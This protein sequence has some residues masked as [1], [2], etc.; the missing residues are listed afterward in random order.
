MSVDYHRH[1]Q[2]TI[3][4][5]NGTEAQNGLSWGVLSSLASGLTN[6]PANWLNEFKDNRDNITQDFASI[7]K[8]LNSTAGNY[9]KLSGGTMSGGLYLNQDPTIDKQAA[10]K[11]YVDDAVQNKGSG[12]VKGVMVNVTTKNPDANGIVDIGNVLTSDA[13]YVKKSGDTM[14]GNLTLFKD[15]EQNMDAATKQ[16]VDSQI[17]SSGGGTITGIE[18]NGV[19]K[20][21]SGVVDLGDVVTNIQVDGVNQTLENGNVNITFST[22]NFEFESRVPEGIETQD[23]AAIRYNN[24]DNIIKI[25]KTIEFNPAKFHNV[26]FDPGDST[27]I[28]FTNKSLYEGQPF[29]KLPSYTIKGYQYS[30]WYW[31]PSGDSDVQISES[32]EFNSDYDVILYPIP[33]SMVPDPETDDDEDEE[34][35]PDQPQPDVND[36]YLN[37]PFTITGK[38]AGSVIIT[39]PWHKGVDSPFKY[40]KDN[41][42]TWIDYTY[43]TGWNTTTGW[44]TTTAPKVAASVIAFNS[45]ETIQFKAKEKVTTLTEQNYNSDCGTSQTCH[46]SITLKGNAEVS[47]NIQYLL[48]PTGKET[49]VPE[50]CFNGLFRNSTKLISAENLRLPG[51]VLGKECYSAMFFGCTN[52]KTPPKEIKATIMGTSACEK[53]FY[54]CIKLDEAPE[55]LTTTLSADCYNQM[56]YKCESLT[57]SPTFS[58]KTFGNNSC[59]EMFYSCTSLENTPTFEDVSGVSPY[60]CRSMFR[61]CSSLTEAHVPPAYSLSNYCFD[62]M[63]RDCISLAEIVLD[64]KT[65]STYCYKS[66]FSGCTGLTKATLGVVTPN[67]LVG[68]SM[69]SGCT[70]CT[71]IYL[72]NLTKQDFD[73]LITERE[74]LSSIG[75]PTNGTITIHYKQ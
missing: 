65:M 33:A 7:L 72:S 31:T 68:N 6:L 42:N 60:C 54:N 56:F 22:P 37:Q 20:G 41:G 14:L 13:N 25:P 18:M 75:R 9:L 48:D 10:T 70:N 4:S 17:G 23:I 53:M 11:K 16:Y 27:S 24:T 66:M 26:F 28:E 30:S 32:S 44:E 57:D 35:P 49:T 1:C 43:N 47:G 19:S 52:L 74:F 50:G 71:D 40:S 15:P 59:Y 34:T 29:G 73:V 45:K 5:A 67:D 51:T 62:E 38:G 61:G 64:N 55:L 69:F 8:I 39:M 36:E 58:A 12:T 46:P 2:A 21:T 3:L 63:F